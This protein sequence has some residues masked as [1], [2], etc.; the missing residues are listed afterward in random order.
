ML[1]IRRRPGQ[2]ILVGEDVE[3]QIIEIGPTRVKL[4]ITAPDRVT[5]TRKEVKLIREQ[6]LDASRGAAPDAISALIERLRPPFL[7]S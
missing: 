3:I 1:I 2:S 5:V 6:N 7:Q 4:G